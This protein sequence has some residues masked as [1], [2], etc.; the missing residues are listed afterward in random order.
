M[1]LI[2]LLACVLALPI[3]LQAQ[4]TSCSTYDYL[5]IVTIPQG[6]ND[7]VVQVITP[8]AKRIIHRASVALP[9]DSWAQS[10]RCKPAMIE[11][12][13]SNIL[14]TIDVH[15]PLHPRLASVGRTPKPGEFPDPPQTAGL[16]VDQ[17]HP[18][19]LGGKQKVSIAMWTLSDASYTIRIRVGHTKEQCVDRVVTTIV[20]SEKGRERAAVL[21][22]RKYL[23]ECGE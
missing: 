7:A 20:R 5:A 15:D 18:D 12:V 2:A 16:A 4:A 17:H 11:I 1:R 10:L 9:H 19:I 3:A 6:S 13:S 8:D 14:F 23:P 21:I 22:D